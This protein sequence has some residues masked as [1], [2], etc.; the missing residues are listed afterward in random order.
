MKAVNTGFQEQN[1]WAYLQLLRPANIVTAWADI[2]VGY[3]AAIGTSELLFTPFPLL[4]LLFATTGLYGGG[5]VFNDVFD[6]ELDARERPER[7]IP[8]GRASRWGASIL[9]SCFFLL[10]IG[11]ALQVSLISGL[12]AL[13]IA[14]AALLYDG[15][16]KHHPWWGPLNMGC[17]RGGNWL[18]GVTAVPE[19]LSDRWWLA[20]I[21]IAYIAA[22]SAISQGEVSGGQKSTG[23]FAVSLVGMVIFSAIALGFLP[24]YA[25]LPALPFIIFFSIRVLPPFLQAVGD[26]SP[27]LIRQAVRAGVLSLI[28]LDAAVAAGFAGVLYGLLVLALLPLSLG[29]ARIFA[30]T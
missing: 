16:C 29:L 20:F 24:F 18:L 8:S 9:G 10:G 11:A 7:P 13:A 30:V 15:V 1:W 19:L 6:A 26:P 21:P 14:S 3:G 27:E 5:I 25:L 4:W 22:I 28:V 2:L 17:C 23:I 12:F